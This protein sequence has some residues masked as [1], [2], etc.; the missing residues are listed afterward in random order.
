MQY[1]DS[2]MGITEALTTCIKGLHDDLN[3]VDNNVL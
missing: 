2:L 1:S 3:Y